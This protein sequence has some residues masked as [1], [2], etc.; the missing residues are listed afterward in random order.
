MSH[1]FESILII[2]RRYALVGLGWKVEQ[3]RSALL[4]AGSLLLKQERDIYP[5]VEDVCSWSGEALLFLDLFYSHFCVTR[6]YQPKHHSAPLQYT[7]ID[8]NLKFENY[9]KG[10]RD[11]VGFD[12]YVFAFVCHIEP[13]NFVS[14]KSFLKG[15]I[16][17]VVT[18]KESLSPVVS[19]FPLRISSLGP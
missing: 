18:E 8:I 11:E 1:D 3:G 6:K 12:Y 2:W 4:V 16:R 7:I 17:N 9:S 19:L 13:C 14:L 10:Q 5:T 15:L